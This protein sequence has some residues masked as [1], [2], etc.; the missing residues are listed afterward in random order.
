[1]TRPTK[2]RPIQ[3]ILQLQRLGLSIEANG[4]RAAIVDASQRLSRSLHNNGVAGTLQRMFRDI[5]TTSEGKT[6]PLL[7]PFDKAHGTDT[8]GFIYGSGLS[9]LFGTA[10]IGS[11]PSSLRPALAAL[12][13]SPDDFTFIDLGCGKGRALF[14][15]AELPFRR[16]IGVEMAG[17]LCEI[18]R[19]NVATNPEWVSRISII[20]QH[21]K[22]F[23]YP[24]GPLLLYLY[25]PF[26]APVLRRVLKNL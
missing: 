13:L 19:A 24:D 8:G 22:D 15:A 26:F 4:L 12:P 3:P 20:K 7:A 21:A 9:T 17:E 6:A 2:Y 23:V 14:V 5:R 16:L 10:Y 11:S 25:N 18:A 1:M